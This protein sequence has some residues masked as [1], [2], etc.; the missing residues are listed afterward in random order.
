MGVLKRA[1]VPGLLLLAVYYAVFGGEH[2]VW[3]LKAAREAVATEGARLDTIR[4]TLDSLQAWAD[5]LEFD[6]ATLERIAR[7]RHGLI[8]QGEVIYL[9]ADPVDSTDVTERDTRDGDPR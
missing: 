9:F 6:D 5:S 7:E 3:E 8:R 1:V 2:S 4:L